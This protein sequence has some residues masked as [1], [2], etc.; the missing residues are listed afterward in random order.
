MTVSHRVVGPSPLDDAQNSD[1]GAEHDGEYAEEG[2][3]IPRAG[4]LDE[5][6]ES[7]TSGD[8]RESG[9]HPGKERSLIGEEESVIHFLLRTDHI[10]T[11]RLD[12]L[13]PQVALR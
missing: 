4:D 10:T 5:L 3:E 9:P 13:R 8:Q 11:L 7:D 1:D 6:I 12:T 2:D